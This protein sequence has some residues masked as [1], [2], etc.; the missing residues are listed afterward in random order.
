MCV[1]VYLRGC[2]FAVVCLCAYLFVHLGPL[3]VLRRLVCSIIGGAKGHHVL[4][5]SKKFWSCIDV[6]DLAGNDAWGCHV[7]FTLGF[8]AAMVRV[9]VK[10]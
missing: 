6:G 10:M 2:V 4:P 1:L 7:V 3:L 5:E 9:G 8:F